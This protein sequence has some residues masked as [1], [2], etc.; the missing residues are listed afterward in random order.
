MGQA[1]ITGSLW[2]AQAFNQLP[3]VALYY[4]Q[5]KKN[6]CQAAKTGQLYKSQFKLSPVPRIWKKERS[7][8]DKKQL[9]S[10]Q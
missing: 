6:L 10:F 9:L 2:T 3:L 7:T 4:Y 8:R 5:R 1:G